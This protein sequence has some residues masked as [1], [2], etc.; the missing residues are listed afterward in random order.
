MSKF[1]QNSNLKDILLSTKN[2]IIAEASPRDKIWGIG[3]GSKNPNSKN[4]NEWK[5]TNILGWALMKAR[6]SL[7]KNENLIIFEHDRFEDRNIQ[8]ELQKYKEDF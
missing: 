4:K 3:L 6:E 1:S 5:G 7:I 2:K 8:M